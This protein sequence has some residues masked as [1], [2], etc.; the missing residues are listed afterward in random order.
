VNDRIGRRD[1]DSVVHKVNKWDELATY[2]TR[3][4]ILAA[5]S[6]LV[7]TT[8]DGAATLKLLE[9]RVGQLEMAVHAQRGAL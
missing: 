7:W 8:N 1:I 3:A 5:L 2:I 9:W 6:W 4:I